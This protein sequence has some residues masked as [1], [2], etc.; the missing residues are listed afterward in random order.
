MSMDENAFEADCDGVDR[1]FDAIKQGVWMTREGRE[2]YIKD[3]T[4]RHLINSIKM[5]ERNEERARQKTILDGYVMLSML[6][7]EM[8]Q[9]S[10]EQELSWLE[11][12]ESETGDIFPVYNELTEEA[13]K[14]GLAW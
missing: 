12:G 6:N 5:L 2:M 1:A 13:E 7:G 11:S 9:Y 10:V 8:A 4:N 3:M 14:R